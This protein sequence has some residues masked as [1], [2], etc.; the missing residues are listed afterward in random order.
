MSDI[1]IGN[2][3]KSEHKEVVRNYEWLFANRE[4]LNFQQVDKLEEIAKKGQLWD[5][6]VDIPFLKETRCEY[7][8]AFAKKVRDRIIQKNEIAATNKNKR[9]ISEKQL[10]V[11]EELLSDKHYL[12]HENK[13]LKEE[14]H[15]LKVENSGLQQTGQ[16]LER[17]ISR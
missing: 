10:N 16:F 7:D 1:I 8:P 5:I 14:N 15:R 6:K 17:A 3:T 9:D 13:Y 4:K 12:M 11:I 2:L